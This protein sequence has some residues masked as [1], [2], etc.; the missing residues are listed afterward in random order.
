MTDTPDELSVDP[1]PV[2]PVATQGQTSASP[3][4]ELVEKSVSTS[5]PIDLYEKIKELA[6]EDDRTISAWLR[7]HLKAHLSG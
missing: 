5:L 7:R 4:I 6:E 1:A 3:K 2:L